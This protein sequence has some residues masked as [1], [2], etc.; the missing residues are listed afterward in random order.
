MRIGRCLRYGSHGLLAIIL[1]VGAA[2]AW[3]ML[4]ALDSKTDML[5][6]HLRVDLWTTQEAEV[7]GYQLR[8]ALSRH[9]AGDKEVTVG[10]IRGHLTKL[11]Q[12]VALLAVENRVKDLDD[13]PGGDDLVAGFNQALDQLETFFVGRHDLNGDLAL[14]RQ[15]DAVL[16]P[17]LQQL[18]RL[19]SSLTHIRLELQDRDSAKIG[20]LI[21]LNRWLLLTV[22]GAAFLFIGLLATELRNAR[23]AEAEARADRSRFQ[24]FAEIASDWLFET[25]ARLNFR[26]V[27]EQVEASTGL[28]ATHFTGGPARCLFAESGDKGAPSPIMAAIEDRRVFRDVTM[29]LNNNQLFLRISGKPVLSE[30]GE[31]LGFRGIG[32]DISSEVKRKERIR[33][34]A[35]RDALTGLFN[36]SFFLDGLRVILD[37]AGKDATKVSILIL[38][39]DKFKDIN[40]TFGH[41]VGDA[42]IVLAAE[43]LSGCLCSSDLLARLGGDEFA[44]VHRQTVADPETLD[45]LTD[46]LLCTINTPMQVEGFEF[47]IGTSIGVAHF[48]RDGASV[49]DLMKAA[50]LALYGAKAEGRNRAMAYRQEMS[51]K[52]RRKRRLEADLRQALEN[53]AL[54]LHVQP[55]VNLHNECLTGG[56]ALVRWHH[57]ELG[58]IG[59]DVFIPIA[60]ETGLIL[61][62]GRWVMETACR[63]AK[64][65]LDRFGDGIIAVN[66]SPAQ[67]THQDLVEEVAG[68][69]D[70]TGLPADNLELEITE[71]LLMRD[72]H[73][74][75]QTL[76]RLHEMGVKLAI[77]DFGTGY[78]SLSYLKR[79]RVHKIKI[80]K[81]FVGDLD[82][83][84]DDSAIVHA[85]IMMSKA[86]GF[87]TLAEGV[88]TAEQRRRLLK[89][90]CDQA[91]GYYYGKPCPIGA[92]FQN[93]SI[94]K[95]ILKD[96]PRAAKALS[97]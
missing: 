53:D 76:D 32:T 51:E 68:V 24:D 92:F 89:L 66:V 59:P 41:D 57:P 50:D 90:G 28:P 82:H 13:V 12:V 2:A 21:Q 75:V 60:E 85:V 49:E 70:R 64:R 14:L 55:Q 30:A 15:T 19:M 95:E 88:E 35:E 72:H 40:D 1:V 45:K 37:S 48:P 93:Y 9:I 80:D 6:R 73:L 4:Q 77:D 34:L 78:S 39:L 25:D 38:D 65:S 86:L 26:F 69:L 44:I 7:E 94:H 17:W 67:F 33:F 63:E 79:F 56:E 3:Q 31:F 23:R 20:Q 58:P 29:S 36:R 54:Q 71:G 18:R 83:D 96:Q 81:A 91:Q 16:T 61:P 62:L 10:S 42:L 5:S 97:A 47:V 43:R 11:R 8:H 52:L 27:S 87:E 84:Q 74:A 46:R 22:V